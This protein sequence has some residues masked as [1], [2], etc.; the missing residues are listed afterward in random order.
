M[1]IYKIKSAESCGESRKGLSVERKEEM[2]QKEKWFGESTF[3]SIKKKEKLWI[4]IQELGN[5]QKHSIC[6]FPPFEWLKS[7]VHMETNSKK[8]KKKRK[9]RNKGL[10]YLK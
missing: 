5:K 6:F 7:A 3:N 9:S 10:I 8:K 4:A 2:Q 1:R